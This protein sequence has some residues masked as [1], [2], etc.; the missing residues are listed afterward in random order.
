M[1]SLV[2]ATGKVFAIHSQFH[3]VSIH[4]IVM[5]NFLLQPVTNNNFLLQYYFEFLVPL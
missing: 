2:D 3:K 5:T 1:T 4:V